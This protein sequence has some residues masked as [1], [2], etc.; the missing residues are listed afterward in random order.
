MKSSKTSIG[1]NSRG[2]PG[3]RA[4]RTW[5]PVTDSWVGSADDRLWNRSEDM[6]FDWSASDPWTHRIQLS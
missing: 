3:M 6:N 5:M 1:Q 2:N 4:R